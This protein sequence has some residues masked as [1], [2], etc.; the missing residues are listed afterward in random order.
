MREGDWSSGVVFFFKKAFLLDR[1]NLLQEQNNDWE[2]FMEALRKK[3]ED[4][5]EERKNRIVELEGL[6]QK[7]RTNH[8]EE[9]NALKLRLSTEVQVMLIQPLYI[10]TYTIS[11]SVVILS[12]FSL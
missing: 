1:V 3:Q 10:A 8:S 9:F 6:I 7:L 5:L 2:D 4:Y 12:F 11:V